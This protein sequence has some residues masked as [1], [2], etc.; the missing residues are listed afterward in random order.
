MET[1]SIVVSVLVLT[2]TLI[3]WYYKK[4]F[5][6]WKS[7]KIPYIEPIFPYGNIKGITRD[8]HP[9]QFT[10]KVYNELKNA[11]KF[12]GVYF[13]TRPVAVIT[14]LD[15][16]KQILV[17]DF[18]VFNDRGFYS[19]E[20]DDP[21]TGHLV[22]LTGKKWKKIR[23]QLTPTFTTGKMKYMFPTIVEVSERFVDY[24]RNEIKECGE[25]ELEMEMKEILARFTIDVIGTV[26]FGIEC[27]SVKNPNSE[28]RR[29]GKMAIEKPRHS[30]RLAVFFQSFP[31][32]A[33]LLSIKNIRDD[34][35]QFFLNIVRN[36]IELRKMNNI[37]RSDF[38]DLLIKLKKDENQKDSNGLTFN[39]IAAQAFVFFV[40]GFETSAATMVFTL[41]ELA[42]NPHIQV[43]IRDV[44]KNA[45]NKHI[46]K[47]TY[48]AMMDMPYIDQVINGRY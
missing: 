32:L 4:S 48:E 18:N 22:A 15:L 31:K 41:H 39:E 21:L 45:L 5:S 26:A 14:D 17:K 34:V 9:A 12:C 35:S 8:F 11:G 24:L 46:G 43:K 27:N 33:R 7:R 13:F 1:I 44:I 38:M 40:A 47:L 6:Y 37:Q 19:N 20:K 16:I 2:F 30:P 42:M 3:F 36:T 29:M 25:L 28:F 10:Q 23:T